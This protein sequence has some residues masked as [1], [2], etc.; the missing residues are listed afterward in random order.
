VKSFALRTIAAPMMTRY[1]LGAL[2][3]SHSLDC[4]ELRTGSRIKA[5]HALS[6]ASVENASAENRLLFSVVDKIF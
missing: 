4:S 6:T 5:T 1:T 3:S 2:D